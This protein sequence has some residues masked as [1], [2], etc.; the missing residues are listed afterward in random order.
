MYF[1]LSTPQLN[2]TFRTPQ[3]VMRNAS[4]TSC[5]FSQ[6]LIREPI[7]QESDEAL[8]ADRAESSSDQ[9]RPFASVGSIGKDVFNEVLFA[10]PGCASSSSSS[11]NCASTGQQRTALL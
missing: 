10:L 6:P 9:F 5:H 1:N 8:T 4:G 2:T 7:L 3:C 11:S